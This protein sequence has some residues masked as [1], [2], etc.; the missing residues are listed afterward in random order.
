VLKTSEIKANIRQIGCYIM[1]STLKTL[2]TAGL[3][4]I[5]G[6]GKV[7]DAALGQ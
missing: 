7:I 3:E 6:P 2:V 4:F 5:P 1:M